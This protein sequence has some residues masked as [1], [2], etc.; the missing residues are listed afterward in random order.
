VQYVLDVPVQLRLVWGV[1][2]QVVLP[3]C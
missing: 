2:G 1:G 3:N